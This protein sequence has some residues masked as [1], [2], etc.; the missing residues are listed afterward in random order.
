MHDIEDTRAHWGHNS[1]KFTTLRER[2]LNEKNEE[3]FLKLTSKQ[4]ILKDV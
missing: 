2:V 3:R 1:E 4:E